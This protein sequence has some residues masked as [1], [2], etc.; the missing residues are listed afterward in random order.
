MRKFKKFVARLKAEGYSEGSA[1][2]IAA[3]EGDKKYGVEAMARK[4]AAA[5]EKQHAARTES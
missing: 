5:R 3:A 4:S 1:T 2:K